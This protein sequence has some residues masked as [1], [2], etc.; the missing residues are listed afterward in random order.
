M[1]Y[2]FV[3]PKAKSMTQ[4]MDGVG[5][6]F[7]PVDFPRFPE[8]R[9]FISARV[10]NYTMFGAGPRSRWS[11][12]GIPINVTELRWPEWARHPIFPGTDRIVP[13]LHAGVSYG[14]V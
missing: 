5:S 11:G 12:G 2:I 1:E 8:Q 14:H 7:I 13:P 6:A 10:E 3:Y 9:R 4:I